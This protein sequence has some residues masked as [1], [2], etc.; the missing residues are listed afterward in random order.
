MLFLERKMFGGLQA[1]LPGHKFIDSR[2]LFLVFEQ[3]PE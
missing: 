2:R 3:P 1:P